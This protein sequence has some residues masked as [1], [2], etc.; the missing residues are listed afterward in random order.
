M[1]KYEGDPR[2]VDFLL[3]DCGLE[4]LAAPR[5]LC[6]PRDGPCL[7]RSSDSAIRAGQHA[8]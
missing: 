3:R 5:L 4:H 1:I 7:P 8:L 6:Y 2:H